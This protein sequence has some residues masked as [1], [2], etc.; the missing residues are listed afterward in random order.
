MMDLFYDVGMMYMIQVSGLLIDAMDSL[1]EQVS[2]L[3]IGAIDSLEEQVSL[4]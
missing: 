4:G 1:E 3:V 2:G